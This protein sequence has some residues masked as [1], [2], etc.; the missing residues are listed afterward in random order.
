MV[1]LSG[2]DLF[3]I[4]IAVISLIF[5]IIQWQKDKIQYK[6]IYNTLVGLFNT[7]GYHLQRSWERRDKFKNEKNENAAEY[8][9]EIIYN[10]RGLHESTVA[11]LKGMQPKD[12]RWQAVQ[13][14]E[15]KNN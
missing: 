15:K 12:N 4:A 7:I 1:N 2:L 9:D 13:F 11:C 6:P 14:G 8:C 10:L 3:F 5:N